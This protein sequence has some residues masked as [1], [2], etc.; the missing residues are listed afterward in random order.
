L[1]QLDIEELRALAN[2]RFWNLNIH[3]ESINEKVLKTVYRK[4]YRAW[5]KQRKIAEEK[6][7]K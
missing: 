7:K 4:F 1:D 3:A 5:S 2:E 6:V